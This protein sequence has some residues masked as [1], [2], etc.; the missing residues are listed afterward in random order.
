MVGVSLKVEGEERE[1]RDSDNDSDGDEDLLGVGEVGEEKC[2]E[3][4]TRQL[5]WTESGTLNVAGTG[6]DPRTANHYRLSAPTSRHIIA[7]M[8]G[9][10]RCTQMGRSRLPL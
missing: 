6:L 7:D 5:P 2:S 10:G 3:R 8:C 4:G 9:R 1:A